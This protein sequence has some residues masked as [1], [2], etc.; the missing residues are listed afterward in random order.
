[1]KPLC[2]VLLAALLCA[3]ALAHAQQKRIAVTMIVEVPQLLDVKRGLVEELARLGYREG[4]NLAVDYSHAAG[5]FP[6]QQQIARK[7]VGDKPDVIVPITTPS[8]ITVVQADKDSAI[9]VVF[10]VVTDPLRAKVVP[11]V[12]HPGGFVTGVSDLAPVDLHIKLMKEMV[13]AAKRLGVLMNPSLP[14]TQTY[15]EML[16]QQA[17]AAGLT[18]VESAAPQ[19]TNVQAA[20]LNLVGKADMIYIP[21]DTTVYAALEAA[22]KVAI[23]NK[24]PLFCGETRS[25]QRGCAASISFDYYDVGAATAQMVKKVLDG[26]KPGDLDVNFLKDTYGSKFQLWLNAKTGS[27]MGLKITED[28]RKRASKVF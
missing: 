14:N 20:A 7:I 17:P 8:A 13:P 23:D 21:N 22:V 19:T 18:V 16:K 3:A 1:M 11:S 6:T 24:L 4:H 10:S 25:V 9:P 15:L 26:A 12:Q 2:N 27:E 28:L 5:S